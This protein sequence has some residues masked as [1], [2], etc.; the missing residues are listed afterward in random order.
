M[1]ANETGIR[2]NLAKYPKKLRNIFYKHFFFIT[3]YPYCKNIRI[4]STCGK[5]G[6]CK[7][8]T[9]HLH[10]LDYLHSEIRTYS[11]GVCRSTFYECPCG[12]GIFIFTYMCSSWAH[13][14]PPEKH[15][16]RE[17]VF[18]SIRLNTLLDKTFRE[19]ISSS[20]WLWPSRV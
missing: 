18:H 4:P 16:T 7:E 14:P 17:I 2:K 15:T 20:H 3:I 9:E 8:H 1:L 12:H 10:H 19:Y 5:L 13:S 11:I 6:N